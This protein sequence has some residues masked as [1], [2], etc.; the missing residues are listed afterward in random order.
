MELSTKVRKSTNQGVIMLLAKGETLFIHTPIN[1]DK[2]HLEKITHAARPL[3]GRSMRA[4]DRLPSIIKGRQWIFFGKD[5][6]FIR[7]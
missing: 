2:T 6:E 1:T 7:Q 4:H 3:S 5:D